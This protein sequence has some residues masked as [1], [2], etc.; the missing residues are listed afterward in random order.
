MRVIGLVGG[1][2]T[3]ILTPRVACLQYA[4]DPCKPSASGPECPTI[5]NKTLTNLTALDLREDPLAQATVP[6]NNL[7]SHLYITYY[8]TST[9]FAQSLMP[10]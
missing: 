10:Q 6:R 4:S 1:P 8:L 7:A 3:T 2:S 9:N 5:L